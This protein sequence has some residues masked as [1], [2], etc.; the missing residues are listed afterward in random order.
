[1]HS[2]ALQIG[3]V[4]SGR[5]QCLAGKQ[6]DRMGGRHTPRMTA[7]HSSLRPAWCSHTTLRLCQHRAGGG[8]RIG[9][10][11]ATWACGARSHAVAAGC[12]QWLC[13][14]PALVSTS[15]LTLYQA[16]SER[17]LQTGQIC[18]P[19]TVQ[20]PKKEGRGVIDKQALLC[21]VQASEGKR[22]VSARF[23]R[24]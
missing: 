8:V 9:K 10:G 21:D 20:T 19:W 23:V 12:H 14:H 22:A 2:L 3:P 17:M 11:F 1:M 13:T 7:S 18:M 5:P 6:A 16:V 24:S 15:K 4:A